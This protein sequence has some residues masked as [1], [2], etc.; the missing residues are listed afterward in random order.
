[1]TKNT[2]EKNVFKSSKVLLEEPSF[3]GIEIY[4]PFSKLAK[5]YFSNKGF[6]VISLESGSIKI[7][8][9]NLSKKEKTNLLKEIKKFIKNSRQKVINDFLLFEKERL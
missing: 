1:M 3:N 7:L 2:S 6:D 4:H 5:R 9:E 8:F